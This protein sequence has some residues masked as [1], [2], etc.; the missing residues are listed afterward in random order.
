MSRVGKHPVEIPAGVNVVLN[1]G[2]LIGKGKNSE[3]EF[4]IHDSVD[5]EIINGKVVFKPCDDSKIS[6][7]MWGTCRAIVSNA[8]KGLSTHFMKKITLV[9]VGYKA[10]V[11]GKNLVMQLGYSHDIVF[12]IP[13][14]IKIVCETPTIIAV[15]GSDRQRVGEIIK[16]LQKFRTPEPYKGKGIIID[17]QYI[18]R[19]EGKKK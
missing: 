19:K 12:E 5:A 13:S 11:Q 16:R 1:D 15:S 4:K 6:R 3:F 9:G 7:S 2:V 18:R 14:D 8:I 17:G 10:S